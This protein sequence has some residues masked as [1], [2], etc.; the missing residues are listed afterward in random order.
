MS[1]RTV[2]GHDLCQPVPGYGPLFR[3]NWVNESGTITAELTC[4]SQNSLL[5]DVPIGM[6]KG[7]ERNMCSSISTF[8]SYFI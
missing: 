3:T 8:Y 2:K 7:M 1:V 5:Y 6:E 4:E